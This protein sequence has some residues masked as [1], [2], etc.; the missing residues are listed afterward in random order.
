ML[1]L[2]SSVIFIVFS[3]L[4]TANFV[5]ADENLKFNSIIVKFVDALD[6]NPI[7]NSKITTYYDNLDNGN[8][9][10]KMHYVTDSN[11][12]IKVPIEGKVYIFRSDKVNNKE[13]LNQT[14]SI[15][16]GALDKPVYT[17]YLRP[18]FNLEVN[19]KTDFSF[20][21]SFFKKFR[22]GSYV[23]APSLQSSQFNAESKIETSCLM[24]I[25]KKGETISQYSKKIKVKAYFSR[26][27]NDI[28][29]KP[30]K[31][32]IYAWESI[33][34]I[35]GIKEIDFSILDR[36]DIN[37]FEIPLDMEYETLVDKLSK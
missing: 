35:G 16:V 26:D 15:L 20:F 24:T 34:K 11:G 19:L 30:Y 14:D 5:V 4:F 18:I 7:I 29:R 33:R 28:N 13:Y 6:L 31:C 10:E 27:L 1:K 12:E 8:L 3:Y 22:Y 25:L 32:S 9:S 36:S 37:N 2:I 21:L 23:M 17:I